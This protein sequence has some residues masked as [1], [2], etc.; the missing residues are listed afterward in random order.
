MSNCDVHI[1]QRTILYCTQHDKI[2]CELCLPDTHKNCKSI[3]SID[4]AAKGVN[5]GTALEDLK[6]RMEDLSK[7]FN[8]L[9]KC[10]TNNAVIFEKQRDDIMEKIYT[11]KQL[12]NNDLDEIKDE[13]NKQYQT[14]KQKMEEA[15]R[16]TQKRHQSVQTWIHEL[17]YV[18]S[19]SNEVNLFQTIKVLDKKIHKEETDICNQRKHYKIE[20]NPIGKKNLPIVFQFMGKISVTEEQMH[21]VEVHHNLQVHVPKSKDDDYQ[22]THSFLTSVFGLNIKIDKCCFISEERLLLFGGTTP[23][24]FVCGYDGTV[25]C[26]VELEHKPK[27]VAI[28]DSKQA[29]ITLLSKGFQILDLISFTLGKCIKASK[30]GCSGVTSRNGQIWTHDVFRTIDQ[31]DISGNILRS[32]TTKDCINNIVIDNN[33]NLY[34][35]Q[36]PH[37]YNDVYRM[38][39]DGHVS[40]FFGH[41]DLRRPWGIDVDDKGNVYVAGMMSNNIHRISSDGKDHQIILTENDGIDYPRDLNYNRDTRQLLVVND[42]MKRVDIYSLP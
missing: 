10:Q 26:T 41:S 21:I 36:F 23:H 22:R 33:G 19:L 4:Q 11:D 31:I 16:N 20:F 1:D 15:K 29:I 18:E 12:I 40:L 24:I 39:R 9:M 42:H 32:I 3:I 13:L 8:E 14:T 2:I 7:M 25:V 34:Y 30:N 38:T 35:N 37:E 5:N 27:D 28:I 6:S 17:S